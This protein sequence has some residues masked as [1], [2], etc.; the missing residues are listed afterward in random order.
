MSYHWS[1]YVIS[2]G[3]KT[4]DTHEGLE[5]NL[6]FLS[7]LEFQYDTSWEFT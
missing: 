1:D 3:I 7:Y 4:N 6:V 5:E 2:T